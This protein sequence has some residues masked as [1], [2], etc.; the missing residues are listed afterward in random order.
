MRI[1]VNGR[2]LETE[3]PDLAGLLEELGYGGALV[4]TA[5]NAAFVPAPLRAG[6]ALAEGDEIEVVAPMQGG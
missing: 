5:L 3:R 6:R 2:P 4:A 1:V